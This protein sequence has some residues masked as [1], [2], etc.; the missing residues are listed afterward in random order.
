MASQRKQVLL[1]NP[2]GDKLYIRD[3]YCSFSSK[4]DYYWP[5]QDLIALSG[6]LDKEYHVR[7]IDAIIRGMTREDCLAKIRTADFGAILFTTGTA[8]LSSDLDLMRDIR[9]QSPA[10]IIASAG[11]MK[12]IG[13]ELLEK[14]DFVD[15][16][17]TDCTEPS[18][19]TYL[20]G[21]NLRPLK[22]IV[23]R[24]NGGLVTSTERLPTFFSIPIPRHDLF[25]Y[26]EYRIPIAQNF[27]FTVVITS[28]GCPYSC[29]FCTAGAFGYRLRQVDNVIEELKFLEQL[30]IKEILFQDPTFTVNTKRIVEFCQKMIANGF[31][32]TWSCNADI[33]S[34]NEEKLSS[35]KQA[36]C[37]TVSIG[38]ESG[39]DEILNKYSKMITVGQISDAVKLIKKFKIKVLGYFIIG[40]PGEDR[41]SIM[42]TIDLAKRLDIDIA[43]FAV[44]TPDI[45]TRLRKEA[46]QM[47]WISSDLDIF[48]STDFPVIETND[49]SKEEVWGLRSRAVREFYL[50]P[51]YLLRRLFQVRNIRD[52]RMTLSNA[53]SLL[54]KS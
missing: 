52:L 50:R 30:K 17:L 46:L 38:I 27:P 31:H 3:Y 20:R 25:D 8:T 49:L 36:G 28:L 21:E 5:P 16:V 9:R 51:S 44:A 26:A 34:L 6:I 13:H 11:I 42:Q 47:G 23:Y 35:M 32:F 1:L 39:S 19:L 22:G 12:F 43:S 15:A 7:V 37:H 53:I 41:D 4:A 40:L 33:H 48:D 10:K 24:K 45:G 54:R 29:G 18:I 2:P 14:Y